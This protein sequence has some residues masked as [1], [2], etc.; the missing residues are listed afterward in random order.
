[1]MKHTAARLVQH[2]VAQGLVL[3]D[4][5]ALIPQ[6]FARSGATPLTTTSPTS[7]SARQ[8]TTRMVLLLR[9]LDILYQPQDIVN[10]LMCVPC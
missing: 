4:P 9:I 5:C 7:S 6:G 2:K 8:D 3:G 1:M 10:G